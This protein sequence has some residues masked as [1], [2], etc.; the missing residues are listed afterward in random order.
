MGYQLCAKVPIHVLQQKE[1]KNLEEI[2]KFNAKI[3]T[4]EQNSETWLFKIVS[5]LT[6]P[7]YVAHI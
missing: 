5:S 7:Q 1:K 6:I 2:S 4:E 3:C